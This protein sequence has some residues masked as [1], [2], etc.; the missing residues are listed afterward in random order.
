MLSTRTLAQPSHQLLELPSLLNHPIPNVVVGPATELTPQPIGFIEE[1]RTTSRDMPPDVPPISADITTSRGERTFIHM[2]GGEGPCSPDV[3][4][5][6]PGTPKIAARALS[7][8]PLH[9]QNSLHTPSIPEGDQWYVWC[10]SGRHQR[11]G[12]EGESS[13]VPS[14]ALPPLL[15]PGHPCAGRRAALLVPIPL[16]ARLWPPPGR[17]RDRVRAGGLM[18]ARWIIRGG[19]AS[20]GIGCCAS[21]SNRTKCSPWNYWGRS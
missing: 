2:A 3:L 11:L 21:Q 19:M 8:P 5:A 18:S 7:L 10:H 15:P 12:A 16:L 9:P 13:E 4:E 6:P 1:E 20:L 17:S 14:R